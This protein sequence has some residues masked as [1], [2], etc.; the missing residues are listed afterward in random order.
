MKIINVYILCFSILI[1]ISC[2]ESRNR[3]RVS[4][5]NIEGI[6][7]LESND[8]MWIVDL[9][10]A[11]SENILYFSSFF[12]SIRAL[13]LSINKDAIIGKVDKFIVH[14]ELFLVL[15]SYKAKSLFIFNK[16]GQ[17]IRK[18]G[19]VGGGPAEYHSIVDFTVDKEN[20][21]VYILDEKSQR[22]SWFSITTGNYINSVRII[23]DLIRS[24]RIQ[25]VDNRIYADAYMPP[26][27]NDKSFLLRE[28]CLKSGEQLKF[29][30]PSKQYNKGWNEL[31]FERNNEFI[32]DNVHSIKYLQ[33]FM[34]TVV[35]IER[36]KIS[37]YIVF[38]SKKMVSEDDLEKQVNAQANERY[39]SLFNSNKIFNINILFE[40]NDYILFTFQKGLVQSSAVFDKKKQT[41]TTYNIIYDDLLYS[42]DAPKTIK[43]RFMSLNDKKLFSILQPKDIFKFKQVADDGSLTSKMVEIYS[44]MKLSN[45]GNPIIF[46]YE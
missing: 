12:K 3:N 33:L 5:I 31:H 13:P 30:L 19:Q 1:L 16:D 2:K 36:N 24:F 46:I 22:I 34:D 42:K 40:L 32:Q 14:K 43:P 4:E 38:K 45:E 7:H 25:F 15:D 9:D 11:K 44:N 39:Q 29:W 20:D 17:F 21:I 35:L 41:T 23:N 26:E 27:F 8:S 28:I 10:K 18:I 6:S 37:A